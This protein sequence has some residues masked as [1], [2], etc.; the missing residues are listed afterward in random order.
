MKK[1][2]RKNNFLKQKYFSD[3]LSKEVFQF[4]MKTFYSDN[5]ISQYEKDLPSEPNSSPR[6]IDYH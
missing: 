3:N 6:G 2:R 5:R 1:K 4:N